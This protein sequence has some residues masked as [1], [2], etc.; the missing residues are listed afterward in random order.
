[1][2]LKEQP[3][4]ISQPLRVEPMKVNNDTQN[5]QWPSRWYHEVD[6]PSACRPGKRFPVPA[7]SG[8]NKDLLDPRGVRLL[9]PLMFGVSAMMVHRYE[10]V[11]AEMLTILCVSS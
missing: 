10:H 7:N 1:M 3:A 2:R 11:T 6:D 5:A 8:L 9:F 4:Q